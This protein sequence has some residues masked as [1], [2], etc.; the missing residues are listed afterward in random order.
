MVG[1]DL[2]LDGTAMTLDPAVLPP[3]GTRVRVTPTALAFPTEAHGT[4]I[5]HHP[6]PHADL[7]VRLDDPKAAGWP[8]EC[9]CVQVH[10][11]VVL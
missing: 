3:I 5:R 9:I 2:A 4:V 8:L 7:L 11:A 6:Q 10:E 1:A